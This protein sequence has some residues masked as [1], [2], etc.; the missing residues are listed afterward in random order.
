MTQ[1]AHC[2]KCGASLAPNARQAFCPS[3]LYAQAA[4]D[5]TV[6]IEGEHPPRE[7]ALPASG[8]DFSILPA[9]FGEYELLE[10][11]GEG[12]MGVVFKARQRSLDRLV[13]LKLLSLSGPHI[14]PEF[15][16]RFRAEAVAAAS[17][18]HPNIVAI[19]EV[20]VRDGQHFFAMDYVPGGSLAKRMGHHP[21]P[22]HQAARYLHDIARAVHYAH[23]RGILHRDLKPS[24]ILLDAED[25]PRVADFG[26]AKRLDS[27]SELTL[28]GQV[29]GSPHYIPPEQAAGKTSTLSRRSDVYGL[30]AILYHLLTG[31]P[32][33]V[34]EQMAETLQLV[35][36]T[37]P[38]APRLLNPS[39]PRDLQTI[40]L[41]CLE[42]EPARRYA[43]AQAM[44][45]ELARHLRGEPV[46]ARP[47]GLSGRLIRWC[48][49]KPALA[50]ALGAL[51]VAVGIGMTG[52]LWAWHRADFHAAAE[53]RQRQRAEEMLV[54]TELA[55]VEDLLEASSQGTAA[56]AS[57]AR[58]VREHPDNTVA[59]QR[60]VS[61]L[62]WRSFPLPLVEFTGTTS[63]TWSSD[64]ERVATGSA[65]GRVRVWSANDGQLLAT[66]A[67]HA[68][69]VRH[70]EF[71]P[72]GRQLASAGDDGTARIWDAGSGQ[73]LTQA[74][75]HPSAVVWAGFSADGGRVGTAAVD[76]SARVWDAVSG[77]PL[78]PWINHTG[79]LCA[80]RFRRD[81]RVL[82]TLSWQHSIC[83]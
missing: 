49:R 47:P 9:L 28:P 5:S 72:G 31:R 61:L 7:S 16:K 83:L 37:D 73:P 62:T 33:F 40:C 65:D 27:D 43:T 39:V 20:G 42:K 53:R 57:L 58:L 22:P 32:P 78:T 14:R 64:G 60:L 1:P 79:R 50:G 81:G 29:L 11:I 52:I 67:R 55:Q 4:S 45:E 44:A 66:M 71:A 77:Q 38:V 51:V 6:P 21:L 17:L 30:G 46:A 19:H 74:L 10:R 23:E 48:R 8:P 76:G 63:F 70:V 80:A 12:G 25:Q 41:K 18:Q 13:A 26:L 75:G 59:P 36:T 15:I 2:L 34:G 82:A 54:R 35:L 68:G 56:L 24:N 3:C 69:T